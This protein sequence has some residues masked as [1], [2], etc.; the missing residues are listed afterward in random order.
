MCPTAI[1]RAY[2]RQLHIGLLVAHAVARAAGDPSMPVEQCTVGVDPPTLE[3][4]GGDYKYVALR[5]ENATVAACGALCCSEPRCDSFSY[6]H[7]VPGSGL[8]EKCPGE[9]EPRC[10][11]CQLKAGKP[12]LKNNTYGLAVRT[13]FV[14][15]P[16]PPPIDFPTPPYENSTFITGC[17][18][19]RTHMQK[20]EIQG[21]T[22]PSTWAADGQSY[23]MGCD[24]KPPSAS[25]MNWM[26]WW[27]VDDRSV[28]GP[29]NTTINLTLVNQFP[30]PHDKVLA[31][32]GHYFRNDTRKGNI[33][34]SSAI[35][36]GNTLYVGAQC[37]TYSDDGDHHKSSFVGR[38]RCWNTWLITSSD[39]GV[40]WNWTA[41]PF[42][43][44]VGKLTNPMFIN[45]GKGY[46][47]AP[48]SY[49]YVHFPAS[50]GP[51]TNGGTAYW[52]G[53]DYILLGRVPTD[54]ILNRS[55]Y[56]FW[57]GSLTSAGSTSKQLHSTTRT[58]TASEW[59]PD[60]SQ[61]KPH[62]AYLHMTGQ[63]HSFYSGM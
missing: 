1:C 14:T 17:T 59:S 24:N 7:P 54:Q 39:G 33:K 56:E 13:G 10:G 2:H 50:S 61:A 45:A 51:D 5:G 3:R 62:F 25:Q 58:G 21:D 43:F 57:T 37:M 38:Q 29:G 11:C 32:C 53:N 55:A 48:D 22:W 15:K 20:P 4:F 31:I 27:M 35:A 36:I 18:L 49:I 28:G 52:D 63:D 19:D 26:N 47:D 44:F 12:K 6:N 8:P 46:E 30:V 23:A 42:D 40:S 16:P 9:G 34:P 60:E 41:T